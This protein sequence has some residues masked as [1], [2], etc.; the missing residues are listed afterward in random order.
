MY[1]RYI[2]LKYIEH[3]L[4]LEVEAYIVAHGTCSFIVSLFH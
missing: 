3:V 4:K 2:E 1:C